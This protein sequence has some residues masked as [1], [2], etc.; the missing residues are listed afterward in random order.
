MSE[1]AD[2]LLRD[3]T[4]LFADARTAKALRQRALA[5]ALTQPAGQ[6]DLAPSIDELVDLVAEK[7]VQRLEEQ[8]A[9]WT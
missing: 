4:A 9:P 5:E 6:A 1:P 8:G 7:V 2:D 3:P